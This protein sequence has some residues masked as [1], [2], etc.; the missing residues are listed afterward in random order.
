M[1]YFEKFNLRR[2]PFSF[3]P[4]PDMFY[5][6]QSRMDCLRHLVVG[7][8]LHRG[9]SAVVG[10]V[11]S[12]KTTLCRVLVRELAHFEGIDVCLILNADFAGRREFLLHLTRLL[13]IPEGDPDLDAPA[14]TERIEAALRQRYE[15]K[16]RIVCL[17]IDEGQVMTPGCFQALEA[18]NAAT[19]Q[20]GKLLQ[21]VIFGQNEFLGLLPSYPALAGQMNYLHVLRPFSFRDTRAMVA[22]RLDASAVAGRPRP[23]F[24]WP[25]L[26]YLHLKSGGYP[27][28]IVRLCHRALIGILG[29]GATIRLTHV[30]RS[31][32]EQLLS[33]KPGAAA[34]AAL[35][36]ACVLAAALAGYAVFNTLNSPG[37]L[38]AESP[39]AVSVAASPLPPSQIRARVAEQAPPGEAASGQTGQTGQTGQA[40]A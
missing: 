21:T 25:A 36:C 38:P 18:L 12:G 17:L 34:R 23:R 2:E 35:A 3:T 37:G 31:A 22:S 1:Q 15:T 8:R 16:N 19:I 39:P 5:R 6:S 40:G 32:K 27:R 33:G 20:D 9:V 10:G 4:D 11:G 29:E 26:I 7:I 14:L 28:K 13:G 30:R 24:T